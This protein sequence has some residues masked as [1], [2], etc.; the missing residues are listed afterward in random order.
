MQSHLLPTAEKIEQVIDKV[1]KIFVFGSTNKTDKNKLISRNTLSIFAEELDTSRQYDN[2]FSI[3]PQ[4]AQSH[5]Q[6]N[7]LCR[8]SLTVPE[9][10]EDRQNYLLGLIY[11]T[12]VGVYQGGYGNCEPMADAAFFE[13]IWQNFSCG[14]HYILFDNSKDRHIDELNAIVLGDWPKPGCIIISPWQG[15][16][17]MSYEWQGDIKDTQALFQQS[18]TRGRRVFS[19]SKDDKYQEKAFVQETLRKMKYENWLKY[20]RS[21]RRKMNLR[22]TRNNFF[23]CLNEAAFFKT[24]EKYLQARDLFCLGLT[25]KMNYE[26]L[27]GIK[28][29][30]EKDSEVRT[31]LTNKIVENERKTE[32]ALNQFGEIADQKEEYIRKLL[33]K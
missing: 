20:A 15:E 10:R 24:E 27:I 8:D 9:T 32:Q 23:N 21:P 28:D 33:R 31:F 13:C 29:I 16:K 1:Q 26:R 3:L 17:G 22:D 19:I 2:Y 18:L 14:I 6:Y 5:M 25:T 7:S 30:L 11:W 4:G 12:F